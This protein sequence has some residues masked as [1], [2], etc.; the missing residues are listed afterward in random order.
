MPPPPGSTHSVSVRP[1]G[2]SII[3]AVMSLDTMIGIQRRSGR[4]QH[5][6]LI[7]SRMRDRAASVADVQERRLRQGGQQLVRRMRGE[8]RRTLVILGIAVHGV[9][10]AIQ[11][12]EARIRIPCF[13]EM[14][15]IDARVEQL[16]DA[17]CAVA[18]AIVSG[19]GDDRVDG[20]LV[21]F[22]CHQRI[23]LDRGLERFLAEPVR[24]DRP[25]DPV[26]IAQ[27][28]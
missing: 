21:D 7:E 11:R 3:A 27:R 28:H 12:V 10:V 8:D 15:A 6:R 25:D 13:V 20:A 23:R 1:P 9:T 17:A 2:P 5:V 22:L 18:Q 16:L 26:P 19:I 24:R 14:D 4:M